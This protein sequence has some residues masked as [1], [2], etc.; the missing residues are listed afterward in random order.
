MTLLMGHNE[1]ETRV[2]AMLHQVNKG[3]IEYPSATNNR[4]QGGREMHAD[5]DMVGGHV[6][7][8]EEHYAGGGMCGSSMPSQ[9][10]CHRSSNFHPSSEM[11]SQGGHYMKP[12]SGYNKPPKVRSGYKHGESVREERREERR[13]KRHQREEEREKHGFGSMVGGMFNNARRA[14]A[15][16]MK[17]GMN[18]ARQQG[19]QLLNQGVQHAQQ[20]APGLINRGSQ[21]LQ[22]QATKSGYGDYVNPAIQHGTQQLQA[23]APGLINRARGMAGQATGLKRG[24]NVERENHS[25]GS[26]VRGARKFAGQAGHALS[27]GART[28]GNAIAPLAKQAARGA[29]QAAMQ[30]AMSG[31]MAKKGGRIEHRNGHR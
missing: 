15:P 12:M 6:E 10:G 4:G 9:G 28:V 23:A 21:M 29:G 19:T 2:K 17:Q 1:A 14:A 11:P 18:Y 3:G 20:Q 5:G 27:S 22:N 30:S 8:D 26:F 13:E 16:L 7:D 24:G 31:A 25:W